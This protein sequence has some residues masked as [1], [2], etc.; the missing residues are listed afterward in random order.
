LHKFDIFVNPSHQE[1]LPTT[2]VEALMAKCIVVATDVGGTKE[3]SDQDDLILV[4]PWSVSDLV[5]WLEKAFKRL[6]QWD[7]SLGIVKERFGVEGAIE[8]YRELI[9]DYLS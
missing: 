3:I 2:V 1:W 6:D 4:K 7:K 9:I 5:T 8:R